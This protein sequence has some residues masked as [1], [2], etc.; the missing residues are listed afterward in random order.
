MKK[1]ITIFIIFQSCSIFAQNKQEIDSLVSVLCHSFNSLD[2]YSDSFKEE[3]FISH[4]LK[5]TALAYDE[6]EYEFAISSLYYRLQRNCLEFKELLDRNHGLKKMVNRLS[7]EPET[8]L[9]TS[10]LDSFALIKQFYYLE[11][12][13]DT[14]KVSIKDSTWLDSFSNGTHSICIHHWIDQS[15]FSLEFQSSTNE[16]RK[17]TNYKG[18]VFEYKVINA[19]A[20]YY[21]VSWHIPGTSYY[22]I[23]RFYYK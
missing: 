20:N 10:Q 11:N 17:Y 6:L 3:Y 19:E 15:K 12:S 9:T 21:N 2:G 5:P 18:D 7:N 8:E 22:E 4:H 14:T 16:S 1:L 13:G 23:H